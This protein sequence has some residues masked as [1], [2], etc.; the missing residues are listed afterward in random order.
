MPAAALAKPSRPKLYSAIPRARLFPRLDE[1]RE[2]PAIWVC[3]PPGAGK[4]TLVASSVSE[5][6][7]AGI[8]YQVDAGDGDP[9]TFFY[10][11]GMAAD[12]AAKGKHKPLPL[13]TPEMH[14][15]SVRADWIE[16]DG[17]ETWRAH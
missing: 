12:Q 16:P 1:A 14:P 8:R 13:F 17:G 15:T 9:A 5:R 6:E 10:Y 4:T 7:I 11:L 3:G 2:H